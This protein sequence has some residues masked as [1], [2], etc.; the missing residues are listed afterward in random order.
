[1]TYCW[2]IQSSDSCPYQLP[3][4]CTPQCVPDMGTSVLPP[5]TFIMSHEHNGNSEDIKSQSV[6]FRV[7]FPLPIYFT[8]ICQLRMFEMSW[9]Q[10]TCA[11]AEHLFQPR[12]SKCDTSERNRQRWLSYQV[13]TCFPV[14][15]SPTGFTSRRLT[16]VRLVCTIR[17]VRYTSQGNA[18]TL[19]KQIFGKCI[20]ERIFSKW[21]RHGN[22]RTNILLVP[23]KTHNY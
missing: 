16:Y 5:V 7:V 18:I 11:S 6:M 21:K 10:C 1:M 14:S 3:V 9:E 22:S 13:E 8:N 20:W 17:Y 15:T 19:A 23:Y 2:R 12:A 4:K